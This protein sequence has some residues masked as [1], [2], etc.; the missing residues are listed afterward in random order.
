MPGGVG[1][2]QSMEQLIHSVKVYVEE[3]I[4]GVTLNTMVPSE[5]EPFQ[6]SKLFP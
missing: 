3:H 2:G 5:Y 1:Q 6:L 4:S